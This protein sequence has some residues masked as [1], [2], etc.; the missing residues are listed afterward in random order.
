MTEQAPHASSPPEPSRGPGHSLDQLAPPRTLGGILRQLGPGLI[1]AGSI[2]GSGELIATTKTGAQAG[3]ALLWLILVGCVIKVFVQVE[4]GRFT[5]A[6]GQTTL[7]ALD[8]LPGPRLKVNWVVWFWALMT[9]LAVAQLGGILGGVGQ[10]MAITFPLTGDYVSAIAVP[11]HKELEWFL[12]W[13][14][15]FRQGGPVFTTLPPEKQQRVRRGYQFLKR[16]LERLGRRGQEALER[17]R[18]GET[19][20]D[21]WTLDDKIWGSLV[22]LL[23]AWL[24]FWGRYRALENTST[25]LVATFTFIT[26]GNVVALHTTDRW[27]LSLADYWHGLTFH[28]PVTLRGANAWATALATFGIIGV[29]ATELIAYPYWCL[30]KGYARF[31]GPKER[32]PSWYE[33]A[34]GWIRVMIFDAFLCMVVYT[35]GTVAFYIMGAAVLYREGLD[36]DGMRMVSTLAE[37]YVPVFG[38]AAKWLFLAGAITVLYST[39]LVANAYHARIIADSFRLCD[40]MPQHDTDRYTRVVAVLSLV[41]PLVAL[42]INA[43]GA[44]PVTLVLLS[45]TMQAA[46]LPILS[47]AAVYFRYRRTDEELRPS[48]LWDVFLLLSCAGMTVAGVWGVYSRL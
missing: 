15:D 17:V 23:T 14:E 8:S 25:V 36:P 29:G 30:E 40:W 13:D 35:I 6:S 2:V 39:F 34:R 5:I 19:L 4:L 3:M 28:A 9:V 33:R 31:T 12:R 47:F 45:G 18:A 46:M 37:A 1:I 10:A 43:T 48:P 44:N 22:A 27:S 16:R 26:I 32:Q 21:P 38:A 20:S 24:L 41:L 7:R 42:V 11:Q